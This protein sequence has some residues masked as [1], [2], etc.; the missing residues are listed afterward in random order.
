MSGDEAVR[1]EFHPDAVEIVKFL[2]DVVS[3]NMAD[4]D[5]KQAERFIDAAVQASRSA[6]IQECADEVREQKKKY[7]ADI[8]QH[9][10]NFREVEC[11]DCC[12]AATA[13]HTMGW[14]ADTVEA[15]K[16]R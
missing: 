5:W 16:E 3:V 12:G 8:F 13:L 1:K 14:L 15:L 11:W 10:E 6:A 9:I 7:P 4:S 2:R